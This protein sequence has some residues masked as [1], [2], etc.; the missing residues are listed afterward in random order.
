[1]MILALILNIARGIMITR[2]KPE[3][4]ADTSTGGMD[5]RKGIIA[6][7]FT[8]AVLPLRLRSEENTKS[9]AQ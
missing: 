2:N 5:V 8:S 7:I 1:M 3:D 4:S 6:L 9:N